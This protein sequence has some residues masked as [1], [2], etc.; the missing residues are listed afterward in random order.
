MR[1][2]KHAVFMYLARI[3]SLFTLT[4]EKA[5]FGFERHTR[6]Q[7]SAIFYRV[8]GYCVAG[9]AYAADTVAPKFSRI[10][11]DRASITAA[12]SFRESLNCCLS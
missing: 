10:A 7:K 3:C 1:D 8:S 4:D 12:Q 6:I 5:S 9:D 2:E 11:T